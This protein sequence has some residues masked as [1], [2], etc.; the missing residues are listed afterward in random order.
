M[1]SWEYQ[2]KC[3]PDITFWN[4]SMIQKAGE[5][6]LMMY[7]GEKFKTPDNLKGLSTIYVGHTQTIYFS[8]KYGD[9]TKPFFFKCYEDLDIINMDT[10][11]GDPKGK[12]SIINLATQEVIQSDKNNDLYP[13]V[14]FTRG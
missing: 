11:G 5:K 4:R 14:I 1:P 13:N 3:H 7:N 8:N 9:I 12:L 6:F 10:G 2:I